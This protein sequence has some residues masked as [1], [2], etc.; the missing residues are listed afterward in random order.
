MFINVMFKRRPKYRC[1][2]IFCAALLAMMGIL[3]SAAADTPHDVA[4]E[5]ALP[6]TVYVCTLP[7]PMSS[8]CEWEA[9]IYSSVPL[10]VIG[11]GRPVAFLL[12]LRLPDGWAAEVTADVGAE[13]MTL[14]AVQSGT[15]MK[16]LLDGFPPRGDT[17]T[18][19]RLL[20][21]TLS[22]ERE[23]CGGEPAVRLYVEESDGGGI[24]YMG[25]DG[26]ICRVPLAVKN[27]LEE[28]PE[29][30]ESKEFTTER[31]DDKDLETEVCTAEGDDTSLETESAEESG[32]IFPTYVGCQETSVFDGEYAVRF[33]FQ[34]GNSTPVVC[35]RGGGMLTLEISD[36]LWIEEYWESRSEPI[37]HDGDFRVCVFRGLKREGNYEFFVYT[38]EGIVKI[39]YRN[40]RFQ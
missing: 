22:A 7:E 33:L 20:R 13:G 4:S 28:S 8:P 37:R 1:A 18:D 11:N 32:E 36:A 23:T 14:T 24:Y 15:D 27:A 34:G 35:A 26:E 21:V 6:D 10:Y 5:I 31:S 17:E 9:H 29:R 16:I 38:A 12:S 39:R 19:T 2:A 25:A 30:E 40:G 3:Q